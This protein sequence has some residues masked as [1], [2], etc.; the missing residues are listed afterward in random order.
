MKKIIFTFVLALIITSLSFGVFAS[1]GLPVLMYHNVT[2]DTNLVLRDATVHITP[3]RLEEHFE[4]IKY[5]GYNAISMDE[6]LCYREGKGTLPKN[7]VIIT[8]D[9]GYTSNYEYAYPLLK[10]YD[11][12]AI[13]FVIASRVGATDT[14]FPHFT[15]QQAIEMEN[16]GFV[17]IESHSY[18][19][20][21]FSALSYAE[22]LVQMRLAKYVIEKNM[23]KECRF[24]AYPYGKMNITSTSVAAGSG[25][26]AV[27]VGRETM[28]DAS[29]E[30][31]FELPRFTIR[32]DYSGQDVIRLI[33]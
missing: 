5:A 17:E 3:Q 4:A 26:K 30:N 28:A 11:L 8:F 20:P 6:Y 10:K 7:P 25:Y 13:I 29:A 23:K 32:G 15:W 27:C 21:D 16:S 24:F 18:T 22:T 31:M 12:K 14:E 2:T 33:Q 19:H 1:G 9:D